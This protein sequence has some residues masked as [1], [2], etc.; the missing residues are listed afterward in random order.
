MLNLLIL[1]FYLDCKAL[2]IHLYV[3]FNC[4]PIFNNE[5]CKFRAQQVHE[6]RH[7]VS[8]TEIL[9]SVL[10]TFNTNSCLLF[11]KKGKEGKG[12]EGGREERSRQRKRQKE[13]KEKDPWNRQEGSEIALPCFLCP[14]QTT[15]HWLPC[16][17]LRK[18]CCHQATTIP[19]SCRQRKPA[20]SWIGTSIW[21]QSDA[22][23][24]EGTHIFSLGQ[25]TSAWSAATQLG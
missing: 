17:T 3:I 25:A 9:I 14:S 18:C 11:F 22:T 12:M 8:S 23:P 19:S 21:G 6:L 20:S 1:I 7:I 10:G 16:P 24:L 13:R 2:L 15:C 4:D 5:F